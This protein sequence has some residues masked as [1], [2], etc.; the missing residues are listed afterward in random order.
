MKTSLVVSLFGIILLQCSCSAVLTKAHIA[1]KTDDLLQEK[2]AGTWQHEDGVLQ[3]E[4]DEEGK[5]HTGSLDWEDEAFRVSRGIVQAATIG[6]NSFLTFEY[7]SDDPD[8]RPPGF[9]MTRVLFTEEG[10]L[11]FQPA[12]L[13]TFE[14]LVENGELKGK[15]EKGRY[16]TQVLIE[17]ARPLIESSDSIDKLFPE[18]EEPLRFRRLPEFE[19]DE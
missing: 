10:E 5:G 4:F 19:E 9:M 17:D 14:K 3:V 13:K 6:E 15:V 12:D 11:R 2:L 8:D 7:I 18:P 1:E 16:S